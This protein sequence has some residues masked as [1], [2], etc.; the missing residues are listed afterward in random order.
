M[1]NFIR[2]PFFYVG[3]KYK[4][5]KYLIPHFPTNISNFIEPFTGGGSVFLNVKANEYFLNDIDKNVYL[6]HNFL[7]DHSNN[8][9]LFFDTV[10]KIINNYNLSKSYLEDIIPNELKLKYKKT[11]YAHYNK[12]SFQK[13]KNDFNNDENIDLYKFYVLLIYGF[14]RMFRFNKAGKYNIPVGNVDFNKNVIIALNNY[15]KKVSNINL[16]FYNLDYIIFLEKL[17]LSK[18]DFI[19]FDPPYLITFSEYNKLWNKDNEINFINILNS[20]DTKGIRFAVSNVV[21]YKNR[22]N[23]IFNNWAKHFNII[24][25][26]SNYISYHD[27]SVKIFKEVLVTNYV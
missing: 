10:Y 8:P 17:K 26:K 15:F 14:N 3:D 13:L 18:N 5:L 12:E 9:E 20:L 27:N 1:N 22:E 16:N 19:Y 4:I 21:T 23:Q 24:P 2:S 7:I 11:Y 25:I 6:L